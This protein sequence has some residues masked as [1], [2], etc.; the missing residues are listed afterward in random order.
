MSEERRIKAIFGM[1]PP[2]ENEYPTAFIVGDKWGSRSDDP[3]TEIRPRTDNFGDHGLLW[4][5]VRC[6]DEVV[7]EIQGRAVSEVHYF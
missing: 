7:V 1:E 5:E 3:V 4:F 2:R 6:G